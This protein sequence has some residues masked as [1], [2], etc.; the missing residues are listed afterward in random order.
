MFNRVKS[1]RANSA[2]QGKGT[3]LKNPE[4]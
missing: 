3:L 4:Q 1:F 2:F